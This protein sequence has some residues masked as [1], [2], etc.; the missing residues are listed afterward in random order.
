MMVWRVLVVKVCGYLP[1]GS[2]PPLW[3]KLR[4]TPGR[5]FMHYSCSRWAAVGARHPPPSH[6]SR[7][8]PLML[9]PGITRGAIHQYFAHH[10]PP[11]IA[12]QPFRV[13]TGSSGKN[14]KSKT[15]TGH[16]YAQ[17]MLFMGQIYISELP[18]LKN[19]NQNHPTLQSS[20]FLHYMYC[21]SPSHIE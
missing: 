19:Y 3:I 21:T 15:G 10:T 6:P 17:K 16:W 14:K 5:G 9:L 2:V 1:I 13:T 12:K 4:R 20:L 11:S 8:P 18:N 7:Q